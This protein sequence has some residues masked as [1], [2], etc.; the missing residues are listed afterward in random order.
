M[1][2]RI[3]LRYLA[4]KKMMDV[5]QCNAFSTACHELCTSEIPQTR[6]FTPCMCHSLM[7]GEGI[8]SACRDGQLAFFGLYAF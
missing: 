3:I 2:K 1:S 7:K 5:Y 4:A 8:P 6:K